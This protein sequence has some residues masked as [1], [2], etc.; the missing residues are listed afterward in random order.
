MFGQ[1]LHLLFI[2]LLSTCNCTIFFANQT[3]KKNFYLS[4]F[5]SRTLGGLSSSPLPCSSSSST[6]SSSMDLSTSHPLSPTTT[7][8][9]SLFPETWLP[10]AMSQDF[11]QVPVAREDRSYRTVY[12]LF[13]K[14]VSETKFRIIKIQRVQNPFLWEKYKRYR[15]LLKALLHCLRYHLL[16]LPQN[17]DSFPIIVTSTDYAVFK[18]NLVKISVRVRKFTVIRFECLQFFCMH[19]LLLNML[20]AATVAYDFD[21]FVVI[22]LN[23]TLLNCR[24]E[25]L[26]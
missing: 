18:K 25:Y 4:L 3:F 14:T 15:L 13:H 19:F 8:P 16:I 17:H 6:S 7:N 11:L 12:S 22:F 10:M 1:S 20:C 23:E 21:A 2:Y 9:P 26:S 24:N 5:V